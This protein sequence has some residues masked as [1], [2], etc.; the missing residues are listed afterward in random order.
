MRREKKVHARKL[1]IMKGNNSNKK[2][3]RGN[4]V[5]E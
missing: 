5:R 4:G 1:K 2:K 3:T